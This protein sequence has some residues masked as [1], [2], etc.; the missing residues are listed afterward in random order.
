MIAEYDARNV[1][2]ALLIAAGLALATLQVGVDL[3]VGAAQVLNPENGTD[4]WKSGGHW[5]SAGSST[6]LVR[7][8]LHGGLQHR[9]RVASERARRDAT[10]NSSARR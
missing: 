2:G 5:P 10:G 9:N 4:H 6:G 1:G 8:Q 3:T 7:H